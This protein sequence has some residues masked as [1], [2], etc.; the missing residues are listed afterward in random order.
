MVPLVAR[1]RLPIVRWT[2]ALGA[3]CPA[4]ALTKDPRGRTVPLRKGPCTPELA[5]SSYPQALAALT[6]QTDFLRHGYTPSGAW[7]PRNALGGSRAGSGRR[8][9]DPSSSST[10]LALWVGAGAALVAGVAAGQS[11]CFARE[12]PSAASA[13]S[14]LD[15]LEALQTATDIEYIRLCIGSA[16]AQKRI[17]ALGLLR[18]VG[19]RNIRKASSRACQHTQRPLR[20]RL[21]LPPSLCAYLER[22]RACPSRGGVRAQQRLV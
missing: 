15:D 14:T 13:P 18:S 3:N 17:D 19:P 12:H 10:T 1:G 2:C 5:S 4:L 9:N 11:E 20:I 21:R 6:T 8:G 22:L 7:Q 16:D